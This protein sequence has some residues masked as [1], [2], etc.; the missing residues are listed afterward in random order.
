MI[1]NEYDRK[2]KNSSDKDVSRL[3]WAHYRSV[4]GLMDSGL[5]EADDVDVDGGSGG[6]GGSGGGG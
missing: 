5:T 6:S 1:D 3:G 4:I 2:K